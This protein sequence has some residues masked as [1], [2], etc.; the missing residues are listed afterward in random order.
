[1]APFERR[2]LTGLASALVIPLGIF[3]CN[4]IIG[5]D[6]Y[7][8]VQCTGLVCD[9]GNRFDGPSIDAATDGNRSE[10][11]GQGTDPVSWA[12]WRMPNYVLP[13]AGSS[14]VLDNPPDLTGPNGPE[15]TDNTTQLVWRSTVEPV[16]NNVPLA[17][18]RKACG[19]LSAR[20]RAGWRLPKRIELV[21]LLD[22]GHAPPFIDRSKFADFPRA[23]VWTSSEVRPIDNALPKFWIV[24]FD[25]GEV[26]QE[27]ASERIAAVLCVKGN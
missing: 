6:D 3:A 17:D 26:A 11:G 8:R 1:M 18:A 5:L 4:G 27:A 9:G 10:G 23:R 16:G 21:T 13:D 20:E 24:N 22:Y 12:R 14:E 7:E 15:I 25:T 19:D 2:L